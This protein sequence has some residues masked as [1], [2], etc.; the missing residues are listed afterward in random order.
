MTEYANIESGNFKLYYKDSTKQVAYNDIIADFRGKK[1]RII[2]GSH[3]HKPQSTG[4]VYYV[5]EKAPPHTTSNIAYPQVFE[6][7]WR[8]RV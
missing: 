3:P 6:L 8:K 1:C 7:E 5:P 4:K 2:D